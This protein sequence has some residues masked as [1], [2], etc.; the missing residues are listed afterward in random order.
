MP[1]ILSRHGN[2]TAL[3]TCFAITHWGLCLTAGHVIRE[4]WP[5]AI[6]GI[7]PSPDDGD[8]YVLYD[9]GRPNLE[10]SAN[11]FGGFVYVDRVYLHRQFDLAVLLLKIPP[12]TPD[13]TKLSLPVFPISLRPPNVGE[14]YIGLGYP[15]VDCEVHGDNCTVDHDFNATRGTVEEI[16]IPVRDSSMLPFPCF[17]TTARFDPGMSG[18]PVISCEDGRVRGVIC[19]SVGAV[20][21]GHISYASLIAPAI[22]IGTQR[23]PDEEGGE[24]IDNRLLDNLLDTLAL[25]EMDIWVSRDASGIWFNLGDT[26]FAPIE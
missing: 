24:W 3:G 10:S 12:Y 25:P 21:D 1:V 16:H 2:M 7:S 8:L 18:G 9:S 14:Q 22:V 15:K 19:S 11:G 13:G 26:V 6:E 17:R 5:Q 23:P 4:A 20:E